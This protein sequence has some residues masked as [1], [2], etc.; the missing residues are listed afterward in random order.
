MNRYFTDKDTQMANDKHMKEWSTLIAIR[1]MQIKTI[2]NYYRCQ[3]KGLSENNS[4]KY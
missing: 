4:D 3:C 1:K 2:M